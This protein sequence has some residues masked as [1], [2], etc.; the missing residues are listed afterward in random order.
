VGVI[1]VAAR[2]RS[3]ARFSCC[4]CGVRVDARQQYDRNSQRRIN[5]FLQNELVATAAA[6]VSVIPRL[7]LR[8]RRLQRDLDPDLLRVHLQAQG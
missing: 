4:R 8:V 3:V 6:S 1:I 7:C 2:L 5:D